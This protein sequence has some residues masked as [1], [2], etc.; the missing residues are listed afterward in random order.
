MATA[1]ELDDA[2]FTVWQ[3]KHKGGLRGSSRVLAA[4]D[5]GHPQTTMTVSTP[6]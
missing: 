2:A 6:L 3:S 4:L 5:C 1:L